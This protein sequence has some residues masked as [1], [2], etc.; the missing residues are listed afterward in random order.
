MK[1]L[2]TP[3]CMV[4]V[5]Y[6]ASSRDNTA[7]GASGEVQDHQEHH[8][9]DQEQLQ[10]HFYG[11]FA[12]SSLQVPHTERRVRISAR[13]LSI[14]VSAGCLS[15]IQNPTKLLATNNDICCKLRITVVFELLGPGL[16]QT[17]SRQ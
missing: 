5:I 17:R 8:Q 13:L 14:P 4:D 7:P 11:D 3:G 16:T 12:G 6:S 1:F 9:D 2:V 10:D 15:C